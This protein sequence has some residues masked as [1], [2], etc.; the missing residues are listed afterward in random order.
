[1]EESA[2]ST[3]FTHRSI[4]M[5]GNDILGVKPDASGTIVLSGHEELTFRYETK[6]RF[7]E[8]LE[9]EIDEAKAE[10]RA[11]AEGAIRAAGTGTVVKR[12]FLRNGKKGGVGVSLPDYSAVGN[13]L[14]LSDR[15]ISELLKGT[16]GDETEIAM[17]AAALLEPLVEETVTEVGGDVVTLRGRWVDWFMKAYASAITSGDPDVLVER[18]ERSVVRRLTAGGVARLRSMVFDGPVADASTA[19]WSMARA[20]LGAGARALMVKLERVG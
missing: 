8:A 9:T 18:R 2:L 5:N 7:L 15:K 12:V 17:A 4:D 13:R 10:L 11:I 14:E 6:L 16:P 19:A 1:M 20:L 3:T